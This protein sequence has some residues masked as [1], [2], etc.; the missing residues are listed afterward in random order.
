METPGSSGFGPAQKEKFAEVLAEIE[1]F[2]PNAKIDPLR[3]V[4]GSGL[5]AL[6]L[7]VAALRLFS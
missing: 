2:R 6:G 7:Q 3:W 1:K 5:A 4:L